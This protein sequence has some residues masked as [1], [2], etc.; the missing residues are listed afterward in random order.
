MGNMRRTSSWKRLVFAM[1]G[2]FLRVLLVSGILSWLWTKRNR[3]INKIKLLEMPL[4][5]RNHAQHKGIFARIKAPFSAAFPV[6]IGYVFLGIPCGIL[7]Q[8]I[9]LSSAGILAFH[10]VFIQVQVST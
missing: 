2:L 1:N 6:M 4:R 5:A 9:G 10:A 3:N 7:A 8:Q